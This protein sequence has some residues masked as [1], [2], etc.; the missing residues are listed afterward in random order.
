[1]AYRIPTS[2]PTSTPFLRGIYAPVTEER[3]DADLPV[4]QGRL[5]DDLAGTSLRNG[6]NPRFRPVGSYTFPLDG[7]AMVHGVWFDHGTARYRNRFVRS[8]TLAAEEEA[9]RALWGGVHSGIRPD[10]GQVGPELAGR[11]RHAPFEHVVCHAGTYLALADSGRAFSLTPNLDTIGPHSFG[12]VLPSGITAHPKVDPLTGE[13]VVFRYSPVEPFLTWST[14]TGEGV[15]RP[16]SPIDL[17][18]PY[19]IHDCAITESYLVVFVCPVV[20]VP[21]GPGRG[22]LALRWRPERRTRIAVIARDGSGIR[23]FEQHTVWVWHVIN[24]FE[25]HSQDGTTITIDYPFW[26]H[27][28]IRLPGAICPR[29]HRPHRARP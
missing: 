1:M 21:E 15:A 2:D 5:P 25:H 18:A 17:D 22:E 14:V 12:G 24:A 10:A 8:P 7:D 20:V 16:E 3:D 23:W 6:P 4:V 13:L 27:P 28:G 26:A 29:G 9:G 11:D 19:M